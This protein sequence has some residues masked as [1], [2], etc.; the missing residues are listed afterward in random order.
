MSAAW[1]AVAVSVIVM[2]GALGRELLVRGSRD[3]KIDAC[4]EQ[5]TRIAADH[6]SRLRILEAGDAALRSVQRPHGGP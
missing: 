2:L 1:A 5:L 6:E 3:G 4:L